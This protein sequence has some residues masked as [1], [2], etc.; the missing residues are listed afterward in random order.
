VSSQQPNDVA[1][2]PTRT[3]AHVVSRFPKISETFILNEILELERLGL[4]VEVFS[5]LRERA[6]VRHAEAA[7]LA[8]RCVYGSSVGPLVHAQLHWLRRRPGAYLRAWWRALRGNASSPKFLARVPMTVAS[9]ALFALEMERRGVEHIH[10]HFATHPALAAH[11]AHHLTGLPYSFTA[12]AHDIYVERPMLDEKVRD[13]SFVVAISDYNRRLLEE[14]YGRDA[15]GRVRVVHC[16]IEPDVFAP[17]EQPAPADALRI[18]CVASLEDYKGHPY[19]LEACAILRRDAVPFRLTLVGDG[20][21]RPAVE[22]QI[23][24][25]G[26]GDAIDVLGAQPRDRVAQ[27]LA[28]TDVFVLPSIVTASGKKEGIPV[29]L[30]EALAREVPVIA[31]AISGVPELVED[32]R[33]GLLVPERDAEALAAALVRVKTDPAAAHA[34]AAT[35]R[36]RVLAEFDLRRNT[37]ELRDL[38]MRNWHADEARSDPPAFAGR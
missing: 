10:A 17:R 32:G 13:A 8:D 23:E 14:L 16:G 18:L 26:L 22:R 7:A 1:A 12:H 20:E 36:E 11:V 9:G 4:R 34:L 15:D 6:P 38:L 21:D 37:A 2:V 33:T 29:V 30:M 3:V 31:T 28:E 24:E 19:L 35:G 27:L 25:L 5:L